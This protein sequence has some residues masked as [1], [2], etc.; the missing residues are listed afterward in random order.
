[1]EMLDKEKI[2]N[3]TDEYTPFIQL[4][5]SYSSNQSANVSR[6]KI[7]ALQ[8]MIQK[9]KA[10]VETGTLM[11]SLTLSLKLQM[12]LELKT[13]NISLHKQSN[14]RTREKQSRKIKKQ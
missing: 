14:R 4:K 2:L 6:K 9:M 1:M 10:E 7:D 8:V 13:L 5:L 11:S 12:Y 3:E